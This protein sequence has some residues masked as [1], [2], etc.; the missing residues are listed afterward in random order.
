M[1]RCSSPE[2]AGLASPARAAAQPLGSVAVSANQISGAVAAA[3]SLT[4]ATAGAA[5]AG[6][7][8]PACPASEEAAADE[9]QDFQAMWQSVA[10]H[11]GLDPQP[12]L[13]HEQQLAELTRGPVRR[14]KGAARYA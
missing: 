8:L 13:A 4:P 11:H 7:A 6:E 2:L 9:T 10:A 12:S 5:A 1:Q 3:P 14:K